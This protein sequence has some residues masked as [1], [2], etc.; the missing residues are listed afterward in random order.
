MSNKAVI[1][2]CTRPESSRIP[3]KA[4][5]LIA[6]IP[7]IEHILKRV[8]A[9]KSNICE[10]PYPVVLAVPSGCR[11]YDYL[12]ENYNVEIFD[13]NPDSPLHR[14]SD[15][16]R[17][18]QN[19]GQSYKYVIRITHDD[20]LIDMETV[21]DLVYS[22]NKE[23][24]GYGVTPTIVD[25]AGVEVICAENIHYAADNNKGKGIELISYFV[26]GKGLPNPTILRMSPRKEVER[27]YRLTMDY[28]EDAN[29]LECALRGNPSK[30]VD[31]VCEYLDRHGEVLGHNRQPIVSVYI[32]AYN[33]ERWIGEAIKSVP[34]ECALGKVQIVVVDD[35]STDN[36]L[37]KIL[38][39]SADR[40][41]KLI[42]NEKNMGSASTANVAL[43]NCNGRYVVRLDADDVIDHGFIDAMLEKMTEGAGVVYSSF[44]E[45]S[46]MDGRILRDEC[47][48][49]EKHHA[50]CAMMDRKAFH[51]IYE[52]GRRHFDGAELYSRILKNNVEIAYIDKPLWSYRKNE[53]SLSAKMTPERA[54]ALKSIS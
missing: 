6:G 2:I 8:Y 40:E 21:N 24:A 18:L 32:P 26:R 25:G 51:V 44:R 52:E 5:R 23:D 17:W 20:I 3:R 1:V 7:A 42:V 19:M 9:H 38:E 15:A 35:C 29:V 45:F 13:G 50:G 37:E 46:D 4:F 11:E 30:T 31:E 33:A 36:T 22:V 43:K 28:P 41:L 39:L 27:P 34:D 54:E 47:D 12:K 53:K 48:P 49:R 10:I 16:L 14:T